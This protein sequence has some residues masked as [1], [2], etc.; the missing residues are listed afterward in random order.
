M[1]Q[2]SLADKLEGTELLAM[3][4]MNPHLADKYMALMRRVLLAC[5]VKKVDPRK[6][7]ISGP[8]QSGEKI[9]FKVHYG[10]ENPGKPI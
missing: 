3:S 8:Y 1:P 2:P 7:A 10:P 5:K 9:M 4:A 6:V